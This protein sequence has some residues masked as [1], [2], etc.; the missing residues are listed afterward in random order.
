MY[1]L[2]E[3]GGPDQ[4]W[5][6][7]AD[8][9][10]LIH[11]ATST[12]LT[13]WDG[14]RWTVTYTPSNTPVFSVARWRDDRLYAGTRN[15]LGYFAND[16]AGVLQYY[17][18]IDEWSFEEK[19]F[20]AIWHTSAIEQG[21]AFVASDALYLWDGA[22]VTT[23]DDAPTGRYRLF[24]FADH[25]LF[26]ANDDSRVYRLSILNRKERARHRID[27]SGFELP[28]DALLR[29]LFLNA[30]GQL[31][32]VT[33]SHG[34]FVE[35]D[36]AFVQ[37]VPADAFGKN[38]PLYDGIQASDGYYYMVSNQAGLFIL[39]ESLE[40]LRHYTERDGLGSN[41]LFAA[42][43]DRQGSIWLSGS[44]SVE[45]LI[46]PHRYSRFKVGDRSTS[47]FRAEFIDGAL[48]TAGD[49]LY[50]MRWPD[51]PTGTPTFV[52]LSDS[53]LTTMGLIEYDN[54][55]LA[56]TRTGVMARDLATPDSPFRHINDVFNTVSFAI[57]PLTGQLFFSSHDG[58]YR[59]KRNDEGWQTTPVPNTRDDLDFQVF[60]DSGALWIGTTTQELYR[61]DDAQFPARET[62]VTKFTG[63][64]GLGIGN[65]LPFRY[66][67]RVVIGTRNGLMD[68]EADRE[69][70]LRLME[71]LP[72]I[73]H[74]PD[75]DVFRVYEDPHYSAGQKRLW[76]RIGNHQGLAELD[77][78][79]RWT[80]NEELFRPFPER[81]YREFRTSDE[82]TVWVG[83]VSG[84]VFRIDV[85]R[86]RQPPPQGLLNIRRVDNLRS[87]ATISGGGQ[88]LEPLAPASN[89]LRFAFALA[90][91]ST[92]KVTQYRYRLRGS[93]DERWSPWSPES[94]KDYTELSG[95]RYV[96]EVAARDAWGREAQA[97]IGFRVLPPWYLTTAAWASYAVF[98]LALL[99]LSGWVTQRWRTRTLER[100]K[101][102]L[103][104]T[105]KERTEQVNAK[106]EELR[107]QQV[108]KDRF[109]ANVSHEFRTPL[110]LT[111]GP[112]ETLVNE[113]KDKLAE[114]V[115][116]LASTALS[117][118][119]KML[120]LVGQVLDL[121]RLEA[122]KLPLR[123]ARYDAAELARRVTERFTPWAAQH[124]QELVCE[125]Y[126]EPLALWFDQ[127][128][129]DKCLSNLLSNAIK[130]SGDG[131]R[132]T[133]TV[134]R[135]S[136]RVGLE[137][138]DDGAGIAPDAQAK[139][140]ERF[141][142]DRASEQV[143]E[144]GTGIGLALVREMIGLHAGSVTLD[145]QPGEG[146]RFTLWLPRGN[147]HF[148]A[149]QLVEPV[150]VAE[151]QTGAGD[152]IAAV[153]RDD[154]GSE[155]RTTLLIVDDN[156][157]LRNFISLR[158]SAS[159]RILNAENGEQGFALAREA[160]P[161]LI[162]SDV[163]MPVMTGLELTE[164]LKST[165]ATRAIPI[166]LLTAKATKRETV[167]GFASGADDYLTKPFDTSEL[168]MR[169][170]AQINT[171]KM[172]RE[173]LEFERAADAASISARQPF[174]EQL[175]R[176]VLD[177]LSNPA[178]NVAML[179]ETLHTTRDTLTRKCKKA[180]GLTPLAYINQVRMHHASILLRRDELSVS[181]VAYGV[182]F[183]SLAYFSRRFKQHSGKSPTDYIAAR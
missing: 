41:G 54:H 92:D 179:A 7:Y 119:S 175:E 23:I 123:V 69:P 121:N 101:A 170:K 115:R 6:L 112:L 75:E 169:V 74:T 180:T 173:S 82:R 83:M 21:V 124:D 37:Q 160:L 66:D 102:Q 107:Q 1:G 135:E 96:F 127:D 159:Y 116:Q 71:E 97:E 164:K 98:A 117:N 156:E 50:Q 65:V 148:D 68:F 129:I 126:A 103:E 77:T 53:N 149:E 166:I 19:Q 153:P 42:I 87:G 81:G 27:R 89:S 95:A 91:S 15:D 10:G 24:A 128:Q 22:R 57:D 93:A 150:T 142:Q 5:S 178:F 52:N 9:H 88:L 60:D 73:F 167:E 30:Q 161:D 99:A 55:L 114:P 20:G 157:E 122:G 154:A 85:P 78:A 104:R 138:S 49:G 32:A 143:T 34:I 144:P 43:E 110:T 18:L 64:D 158:L 63:T 113:H 106:V 163:M 133:V 120:A 136:D 79:G 47:V 151:P 134:L 137:V 182:G 48:T 86:S 62:Q 171:R 3:H 51:E 76:Y 46:P 2:D 152:P 61:I 39:S 56:T 131:S 118:A 33:G 59:L 25:W 108:L 155:D 31:V 40:V 147:A 72:A 168:I 177:N 84:E 67:D 176:C 90:D 36:G 58:A 141:Y 28:A 4:L 174:A 13:T 181:E 16:D 35:Q 38:A 111:I 145:S 130:Y 44:P 140:F 80:V 165:P 105:V 172:I 132:I 17:S 14:E 45:Q 125:D 100:Q 29:A 183:E 12:G 26:K 70:Q 146:A 11:A 8:D 139:V 109:F 94:T 162:I